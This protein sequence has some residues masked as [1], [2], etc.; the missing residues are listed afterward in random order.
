MRL[1]DATVTLRLLLAK[2]GS[3]SFVLVAGLVGEAGWLRDR[4]FEE[5]SPLDGVSL[6]PQTGKG[7][8]EVDAWAA[9]GSCSSAS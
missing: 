2:L 1:D 8:R 3:A 9:G 4:S 7:E 5:A 6:T